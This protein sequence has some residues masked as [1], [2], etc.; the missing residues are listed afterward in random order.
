MELLIRNARVVS[1]ADKMNKVA[2]ILIRDGKIAQ[3]GEN[4]SSLGEVIDAEIAL[5]KK[6]SVSTEKLM[7]IM[8]G[9]D[10]PTG[11][12]VANKDDLPAIYETGAGRLRLR[13]RIET[14][15]FPGGRTALVVIPTAIP[16]E[17]FTRNMGIFA[18]RI[19]GSFSL[20]S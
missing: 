20:S 14:E 10:F 13:G 17:P 3:V 5:I 6:P 2:D 19:S 9:P 11:G 4:L 12:I 7:E 16:S 18:G 8:P 1:P 15:K